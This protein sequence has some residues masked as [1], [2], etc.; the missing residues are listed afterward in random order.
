MTCDCPPDANGPACE[1]LAT[2]TPTVYPVDIP[3]T[4]KMQDR[5]RAAGWAPIVETLAAERERTSTATK[6]SG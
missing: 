2:A 4:P 6:G 3:V 5:M 1:R